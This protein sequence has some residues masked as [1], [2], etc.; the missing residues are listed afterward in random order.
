MKLSHK[1]ATEIAKAASILSLIPYPQ[2]DTVSVDDALGAMTDISVTPDPALPSG[3]TVYYRN[4]V[5]ESFMDQ[6]AIEDSLSVHSLWN[7]TDGQWHEIDETE[8]F[9]T[10]PAGENITFCHTWAATA[11]IARFLLAKT[12]G[13]SV[14]A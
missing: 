7:N 10:S 5:G 6:V 14:N 9:A 2:I 3:A 13:A 12:A 8:P 11:A 4:T 1:Q